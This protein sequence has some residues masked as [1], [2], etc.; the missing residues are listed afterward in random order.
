MTSSFTILGPR[1]TAMILITISLC[2]LHLAFSAINIGL[3]SLTWLSSI[4]SSLLLP[5]HG[6][7]LWSAD[8]IIRL[9]LWNTQLCVLL[10]W[11]HLV[12]GRRWHLLHSIGWSLRVQTWTNVTKS[13]VRPVPLQVL[14]FACFLNS[15][16]TA[17]HWDFLSCIISSIEL[18]HWKLLTHARTSWICS[19]SC[20]QLVLHRACGT[21]LRSLLS[22]ICSWH[23]PAPKLWGVLPLHC[24]AL[25]LTYRRW[26]PYS[27]PRSSRHLVRVIFHLVRQIHFIFF[28]IAGIT[29]ILILRHGESW[30]LLRSISLVCIQLVDVHFLI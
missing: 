28:F 7:T 12:T 23:L 6:F 20:I 27:R 13:R 30:L 18:R 26:S 3:L 10:V 1:W 19:W 8:S 24:H 17:L 9:Y 25:T 14:L 21:S 2:A 16:V 22:R 11:R 15:F 29:F 4:V 5:Y